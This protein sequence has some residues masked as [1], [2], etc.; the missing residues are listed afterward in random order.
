M[1]T[2]WR[3]PGASGG[4]VPV[5][6][7][8]FVSTTWSPVW[9]PP[10]S[11]V[12]VVKIPGVDLGACAP[13]RRS[14]WRRHDVDRDQREPVH[15][16]LVVLAALHR[17]AV[18]RAVGPQDGRRRRRGP[19]AAAVVN[20][21]HEEVGVEVDPEDRS[22]EMLSA[23]DHR[24]VNAAF[25]PLA[26]RRGSRGEAGQKI[27]SRRIHAEEIHHRGAVEQSVGTER[28]RGRV[29]SEI[30]AQRRVA[31]SVGLD[32][33]DVARRKQEGVVV[34]AVQATVRSGYDARRRICTTGGIAVQD[35]VE[36]FARPREPVD[37]AEVVR[38]AGIRRAIEPAVRGDGERRARLLAVGRRIHLTEHLEAVAGR[39]HSE[40]GARRVRSAETGRAIEVA[41]RRSGLDE[42]RRRLLAVRAVEIVDDAKPGAGLIHAE[43]RALVVQTADLGRAVEVPVGSAQERSRG[44]RAV[45][46]RETV[47]DL[48]F[49][50]SGRAGSRQAQRDDGQ[51]EDNPAPGTTHGSSCRIGKGDVILV[52]RP[53]RAMRSSRRG[54][55]A[56]AWPGGVR[57]RD[58]RTDG[59]QG[60]G[61]TTRRANAAHGRGPVRSRPD[62]PRLSLS[63]VSRPRLTSACAAPLFHPRSPAWSA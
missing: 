23:R 50:L 29:G 55:D 19:I 49:R 25:R 13:G 44:S 6:V 58:R 45:R 4:N 32:A 3:R 43:N 35:H 12:A 63:R 37:R 26:Q 38:S 28:E 30:A 54:L 8:W 59:D 39:V 57:R 53:P 40:H 16:A 22:A 52:P 14:R 2:S 24:S 34:G 56:L 20:R 36:V 62:R 5:M 51:N 46:S 42:L 18:E 1:R 61:D 17:R 10:T 27:R 9:T 15:H 41:I 60:A 47:D 48:V 7:R 33:E 21:F 11:S 31:R